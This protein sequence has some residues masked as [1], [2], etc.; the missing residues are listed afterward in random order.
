MTLSGAAPCPARLAAVEIPSRPGRVATM[1]G[2][3]TAYRA[4]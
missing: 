3:F 2:A 4:A 1:T